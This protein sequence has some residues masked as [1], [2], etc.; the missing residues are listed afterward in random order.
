MICADSEIGDK[1][2]HEGDSG[3]SLVQQ[4]DKKSILVG[5]VLGE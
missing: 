4:I 2:L 1:E 3:S 5:V